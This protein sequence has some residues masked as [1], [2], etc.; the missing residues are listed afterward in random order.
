[1]QS[2]GWLVGAVVVGVV[3]QEFIDPSQPYL[4]GPFEVTGYVVGM[5]VGV[6]LYVAGLALRRGIR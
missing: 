1:M 5:I 3:L 6:T 4:R 2:A